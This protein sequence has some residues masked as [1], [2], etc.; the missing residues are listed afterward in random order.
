[1]TASWKQW[2]NLP[3]RTKI[4]LKPLK[5]SV[6]PTTDYCIYIILT[7]HT[8]IQTGK[9]L[10]ARDSINWRGPV[11]LATWKILKGG[12]CTGAV[13]PAAVGALYQ[14]KTSQKLGGVLIHCSQQPW[15]RSV[16]T[17]D[18]SDLMIRGVYRY[19]APTHRRSSLSVRG[20]N[21]GVLVHCSD[22]PW[23]QCISTGDVY[24]GDRTQWWTNS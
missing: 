5:N 15:E 21:G 3:C 22:A 12:G 7:K 23:E 8:L 11:R 2:R 16:S 19:T 13:L 9:S 17:G 4:N 14:Y 6:M 1:M 24:K 10:A 20:L 18:T